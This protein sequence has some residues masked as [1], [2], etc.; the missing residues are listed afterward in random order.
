M[1]NSHKDVKLTEDRKKN[2]RKS[3]KKSKIERSKEHCK[4]LGDWARDK[5]YEELYSDEKSKKL[6]NDSKNRMK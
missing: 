3:H 1:S 4:Q 6:K 2:M 5:T